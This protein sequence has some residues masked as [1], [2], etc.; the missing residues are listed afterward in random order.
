[1]PNPQNVYITTLQPDNPS[2][3]FT[4][5]VTSLQFSDGFG[6]EYISEKNYFVKSSA[7]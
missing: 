4:Y 3:N 5:V 1:M 7:S 6:S 2:A